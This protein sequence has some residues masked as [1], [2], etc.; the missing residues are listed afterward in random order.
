MP[1]VDCENNGLCCFNGCSN[2]CVEPVKVRTEKYCVLGMFS[3]EMVFKNEFLF[4]ELQ[5]RV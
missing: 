3:Y 5:D 4:L 1:D 2:R